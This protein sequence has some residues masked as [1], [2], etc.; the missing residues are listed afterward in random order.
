MRAT[1][2]K[3]IVGAELSCVAPDLKLVRLE[4]GQRWQFFTDRCQ[5]VEARVWEIGAPWPDGARR[6]HLREESGI[7]WEALDTEM[8]NNPTWTLLSCPG[9]E[10]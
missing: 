3:H 2:V 9:V 5:R 4:I 7:S 6:V 1:L 10:R 8:L